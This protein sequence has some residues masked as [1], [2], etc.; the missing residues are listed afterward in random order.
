MTCRHVQ[1]LFGYSLS[2]RGI[3]MC[4]YFC[5][6]PWWWHFPQQKHKSEHLT[7]QLVC[8]FVTEALTHLPPHSRSSYSQ[9]GSTKDHS[10]YSGLFTCFLKSVCVLASFVEHPAEP[11]YSVPPLA[12]CGMESMCACVEGRGWQRSMKLQ[13]A[14]HD[15]WLFFFFFSVTLAVRDS[16]HM[17]DLK[18]SHNYHQDLA[19]VLW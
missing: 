12:N 2:V 16:K 4:I 10:P 7:L 3:F 6:V 18:W 14:S 9:P 15:S 19:S 11:L 5:H 13:I 1:N 8:A 17:L